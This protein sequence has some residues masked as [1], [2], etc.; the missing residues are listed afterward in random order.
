MNMTASMKTLTALAA[1]LL[2]GASIAPAAQDR[3][4]PQPRRGTAETG[5]I[6][7]TLFDPGSK[8]IARFG[9]PDEIQALT[10]GQTGIGPAG[11]GGTGDGRGPGGAGGGGGGG[12]GS[13][14]PTLDEGFRPE[15]PPSII[16]DPFS[17]GLLRQNAP[18]GQDGD[19]QM[20]GGGRGPAGARGG[21]AAPTGGAGG[22]GESSI[23][24]YTRW[25]YRKGSS[26]YAFVLDK[27]NRVV[28]IEAVGLSDG[29][30]RTRRGVTFGSTFGALINKY[31]APDGYEISGTNMVVRYLTRD[32]VAFRMQK[33]DAK[34]PH[35][36]T[37]IVVAAG[38]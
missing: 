21:S 34:R 6:G 11:G 24:T 8:V 37:G 7:I 23:V 27:F 2:V 1:T 5:L 38:R 12:G 17:E 10:V 33:V 31:N 19:L 26:R 18:G 4:T 35:V 22:G 9:N 3:S 16:G 20:S 13:R 25:I 32:R 15:L 28:Q 14:T 36:V 29:R 30:V